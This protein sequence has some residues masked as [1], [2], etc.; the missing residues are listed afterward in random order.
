MV[1]MVAPAAVS[2]G[3]SAAPH[4]TMTRN[5]P[6]RHE[7]ICSDRSEADLAGQ[8]ETWSD[9]QGRLHE[10]P[11]EPLITAT[12]T[13]SYTLVRLS[14]QLTVKTGA[15]G[16]AYLTQNE[17]AARSCWFESGRG[18]QPSLLRSF[19]WQATRLH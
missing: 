15:Y 5:G 14:D 10:R 11:G 6:S 8:R 1:S 13:L 3:C 17:V 2:P 7:L 4:V 12:Y 16:I 19:G 18:H 9:L